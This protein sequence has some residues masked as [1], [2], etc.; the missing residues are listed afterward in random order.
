M[1]TKIGINRN[2]LK[3]IAAISM[4]ID[5]L[6]YEVYPDMEI[7]RIIGRLAYP[8]FAY[9]IYEGC[10]YTR[11]RLRYFLQVFLLG[12]ICFAA[13]YIYSKEVYGNILLTFSLS[14]IILSALHYLKSYLAKIV[15]RDGSMKI[16]ALLLVGSGIFVGI[17]VFLAHYICGKVYIDYGFAGVMV[18]V[19]VELFDVDVFIKEEIREQ[20][21]QETRQ[22]LAI[23]LDITKRILLLMGFTIGLLAVIFAE[24][25]ESYQWYSLITILLLA[26]YNGKKGKLKMKYFFYLYYPLHLL[27][28]EAIAMLVG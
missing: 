22:G 11:N 10:K 24:D 7:L 19:F 15:H 6:G 18:P 16:N 28:V 27:V 13:Y 12:M 8:I 23:L 4:F 5:H 21:K 9:F 17:T 2:V 1:N 26:V 3:I 20:L 25:S 14:I